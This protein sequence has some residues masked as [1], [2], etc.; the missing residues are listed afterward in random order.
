[1]LTARRQETGGGRFVPTPTFVQ[2][3]YQGRK[4]DRRAVTESQASGMSPSSRPAMGR[5]STM[6]SQGGYVERSSSRCVAC[7]SGFLQHS[8]PYT[9][10]HLAGNGKTVAAVRGV[11]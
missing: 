5:Q 1:M 7:V 9:S 10:S 11:P 8:W 4:D 3:E 2:A 6:P